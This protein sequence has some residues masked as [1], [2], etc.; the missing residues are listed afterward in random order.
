MASG[1]EAPSSQAPPPGGAR[2]LGAVAQYRRGSVGDA[3]GLF[4]RPPHLGGLAVAVPKRFE[5]R[6]QQ[7]L[8]IVVLERAAFDAFLPLEVGQF[9]AFGEIR[10]TDDRL[11]VAAL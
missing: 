3:H 10:V 6:L 4:E 9:D 1:A 2:T 11:R 5:P 7:R 8:F